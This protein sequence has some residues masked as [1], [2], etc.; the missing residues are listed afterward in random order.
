MHAD[1]QGLVKN[2]FFHSPCSL[3]HS[4]VNS[5]LVEMVI[6]M[7]AFSLTTLSSM[8]YCFN[9]LKG[10]EKKMVQI[11]LYRSKGERALVSEKLRR[12]AGRSGH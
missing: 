6:W 2:I 4:D 10:P 1:Q 7:I 9:D 12:E 8:L 5:P 3:P 11:E